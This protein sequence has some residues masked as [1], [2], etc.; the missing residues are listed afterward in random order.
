MLQQRTVQTRPLQAPDMAKR[1]KIVLEPFKLGEFPIKSL[2]LR[3]EVKGRSS[4]SS[5]EGNG[6]AALP[7]APNAC[8][9]YTPILTDIDRR[10]YIN[11]TPAKETWLRTPYGI[12]AEKASTLLDKNGKPE[13]LRLAIEADDACERLFTAMDTKVKRQ[14][15]KEHSTTL[16]DFYSLC[17]TSDAEKYPRC[18][19]IRLDMRTTQF[20]IVQDGQVTSGMGWEFIKDVCFRNALVKAIVLP[21]RVWTMGNK[22]GTNLITTCLVVKPGAGSPE[23]VITD[24]PDEDLL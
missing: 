12:N 8:D 17:H 1:V 9:H 13:V 23:I 14:L 19:P 24:F 11:L 18:F 4:G 3:K 15:H 20:K 7:D 5:T 21:A 22:G 16:N 2:A 6:A 10:P